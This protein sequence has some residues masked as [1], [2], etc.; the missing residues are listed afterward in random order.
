MSALP[1]I[2]VC[3][4]A[5]GV[6][7]YVVLDGFDLGIGILFPFARSHAHR[8]LMMNSVAPV[9][10]G[11][12]TWLVMGGVALL[13][14]F[15]KAYAILLS[16]LYIPIMLMLI[17]LIFRGV[18]FEFRFKAHSSRYLWDAAFSLG[19]MLTAFCQG[20]TL[21]AVVQG[22]QVVDGAYAGG[23]YDW[24][25]PFSVFTGFAVI[26][27]YALLGSSWLIMKTEH[28]LQTWSYKAA[29]R[30]L[31]LMLSAVAVVSLWT[32]FMQ[33]AIRERWFSLPNF[34]Y[35]SQVPFA[36]FL[37]ATGCWYA[38]H[39]R[40]HSAPFFCS[41]G[42]FLLAYLGLIISIWPYIVPRALTYEE[43][44]SPPSS[45]LFVLVG[46]VIIVPV[47]LGYTAFGYRIFSGKVK[48][49]DHYH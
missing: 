37:L 30:C 3:I 44:A 47:I 42:L 34:F 31:F 2:W 15:P 22:F 25:T 26:A 21:G 19:S 39:R 36:T 38:L 43:A 6:S 18:S 41:V 24:F 13:A 48:A 32:P 28:D 8:D 17:A 4:I 29:Q 7:I 45:Q 40:F 5:A 9:W 20:L 33:P 23:A 16:A 11:N 12:E 1:L 14:A 27:G 35:L 46:F 49:G 10:D